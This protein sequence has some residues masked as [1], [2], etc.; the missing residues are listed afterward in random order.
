MLLHCCQTMN[1]ELES[2]KVSIGYNGKF[3][4]YSIHLQGS[5][6][7]SCRIDY[8]PWCSSKLLS[9]LDEKYD[10]LLSKAINIPVDEITLETYQSN[11]IPSE[12]KTDEWWKKR[13][14]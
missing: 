3:R 7:G 1:D 8:C 5:K 9:P 14:L 13:G 2:Q 4:A 12:F 6:N 10:E 11:K